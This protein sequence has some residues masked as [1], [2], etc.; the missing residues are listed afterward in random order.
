MLA[1][2]PTI[3]PDL[4]DGDRLLMLQVPKVLNQAGSLP[5]DQAHDDLH[6][7]VT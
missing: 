5:P 1:I 4:P 3:L 2:D 6:R 7:V